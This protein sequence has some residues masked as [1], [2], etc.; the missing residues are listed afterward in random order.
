LLQSLEQSLSKRVLYLAGRRRLFVTRYAIGVYLILY[1]IFSLTR[2]QL[3]VYR[4]GVPFEILSN[5]EFLAEG[6]AIKDLLNPDRILIGSLQTSGGIAAAAALKNVYLSWVDPAKIIT[7]NLWSSELAKLVANAMLAQRVSSINT[8][9]ALCERTGANIDEVAQTVG[10]DQRLGPRFLKAGIG[11]GGSCFKKDILSLVYLAKSLELPEVGEYWMQVLKINEF[12]RIRF[13][14]RILAKL[15]GNLIGKKIAILGYAFKKDTNDIRESPAID[16]VKQLIADGPSEIAIFDPHCGPEVVKAEIKR[17]YNSSGLELLK[18]QGPIEVY[19]E[20]YDACANASAVLILT[21]WD[22]FRY[23]SQA[24]PTTAF[25]EGNQQ[26]SNIP[27]QYQN[28]PSE[29]TLSALWERKQGIDSTRPEDVGFLDPLVRFEEDPVCPQGC[30][31]CERAHGEDAIA[32]ENLEWA[33][34]AYHMREPKWVF[35]GRGIVDIEGMEKLGFRVETI[36]RAGTRSRLN[37]SLY[38]GSFNCLY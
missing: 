10:L 36:G 31:E 9:S 35:D 7:V 20:S 30:R 5:P 17:L 25:H 34:I 33:R 18:P 2:C 12:Q 29:A 6:T 32:H 8:I 28:T 11:F 27:G 13:V 21:D 23:P 4:P 38:S 24:I 15:N 37:G 22:Q 3:A 1:T 26:E 16:V 14:R 19:N